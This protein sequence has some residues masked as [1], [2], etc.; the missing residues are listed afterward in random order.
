MIEIEQGDCLELM[1]DIHDESIDLILTD[2]PYKTTSR[3]NAGNS[4]GMLQKKIN[5]KGKVF[6]HNDIKPSQYIPE[7][8]RILKDG[9]HCYI[10]TNHVNLQEIL[11]VATKCGFKFIKSLIWD[12]GNKIMGQFYMSQF[13]YILFFRKGKGVKI[14]NCGTSD[15]LSVPNKKTKDKNGNNIHDTE[16][17]VNLM[18]TLIGNSSKQNEVVLDPFMGVG[19]TIIAG[20]ELDRNV[21]G[22]ELDEKYFNIAKERIKMTLQEQIE[23]LEK[24]LA[25]TSYL[26]VLH[27]EMLERELERLK[28]IASETELTKNE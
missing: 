1:K 10:M 15:I 8:Y 11:N 5:M 4:G 21:I 9:S 6:N 17:P 27:Q 28:K 16:K 18:K 24:E 25:Q 3:G 7:F 13:E 19:S 23:K 12:K 14:N 22:F 2:P 26:D 20:I